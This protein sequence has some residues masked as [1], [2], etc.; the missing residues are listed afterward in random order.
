MKKTNPYWKM[1]ACLAAAG[2][3]LLGSLTATQAAAPAL[4]GSL[5]LRPLTPTEI[6]TYGIT[7][8]NAQFSAGCKTV[9]LGEPV[10]IDAMV[11]AAIARS[12]IV[13]VTWSLTNNTSHS[14]PAF[15]T[16]PLSNSV[17]LYN[18]S[19]RYTGESATPA[20]QLA[21][22]AFFRTDSNI[23]GSYTVKATIT[24]V[25]SGSTNLS[26]TITAARYLGLR[27]CAACHSGQL[28]GAPSI[29]NTYTNTAHASMF[30]RGIDG[31]VSSHYSKNC[32]SCHTLG[33]DTNSFANNNGGFDDVASSLGWTFPTVLTN[34][35]W[36]SMPQT[37]QDLGNI[38]CEN[39]HGPGSQ[40]PFSTGVL[41]NTNAISVNWAAGDCAQCHD[42]MTGHF[43]NGEWNNSL[44]AAASRTP[45]GTSRP[46][47]IRCH[48]APGFG[49]WATAGG[50]ALQNQ[51]PNN[52]IWANASSTNV[53]TYISNTNYPTYTVEGNPP[54]TT[55]YPITCQ[56]CHDPHN[57]SNP[58]QLR[59]G[60]NLT[61]SDGTV[62]TNAGSG[63]FCMEC[64][65]S[66]NGS[67]T[68]MM[69][70]YPLS[71]P[72]WAGGSAFGTHDSPQADML[73]G[74]NA[75]TYGQTIPSAPHANVISNTCAACHMQVIASTDPA[76]TKAGGHTFKMSYNV[77]N[78][79]VVAK[80]P[81]AY[82]CMQCHGNVNSFDIPAPDYV[83]VGYSQGIQTQVQQLLNK[84]STLYPPAVYQANPA[85][86]VADGKVK[87]SLST[88]TNMPAKFLNAAYNFQFVS[89]DGSLGVHNGPFAVG[90]LKA[91]IGNLSGDANGDGLPDSW[92]SAYFGANFAS[93]PLAGPNGINN[94][95]GLPNWAMYAMGLN[96]FSGS[97]AVNGVVYVND[98]NIVNGATNTIAIYTAAEI[99][100]D[101]QVGTTY[102]IQSISALT[103][104]WSNISTNIPGTGNT[105]SYLTPTRNNTQMFYR[106]VH[107]P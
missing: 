92:Q 77:T 4:S 90:L 94:T 106:V 6:K 67:V 38:Q 51:Y 57:A 64:H 61:L 8:S 40:H 103:G 30:A 78:N 5:T 95:N 18:T 27:S 52:I 89:M 81:V 32:I 87:T 33:Y 97:T 24:T 13:G 107:T 11:N 84:L 74:V 45:S 69:A 86:Y 76:F 72:N 63:G 7:G 16:S 34:G 73:E 14:L 29:F 36:A 12:N 35:N 44:H 20:Y 58:H 42:S 46:Q 60:Y 26:V 3:T 28:L 96:P 104:N 55:Y 68:N 82:V 48:T 98:G 66:R 91:S 17:P 75:I 15:M 1:S 2:L 99:A 19:D 83:G 41:G 80:V 62:V 102:T 39:C 9:A 71:Q 54:N 65:N 49:G 56:A 105:V 101:T 88:Y 50:M 10:Y 22:R 85:N 21:D 70:K 93:N 79:G 47:C 25:G 59:M 100:F 43:K 53:V 37:L 23:E 31:L